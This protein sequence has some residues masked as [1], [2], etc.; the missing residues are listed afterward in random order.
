MK[1]GCYL[2]GITIVSHE[3][4][5]CLLSYQTFSLFNWQ[6]SSENMLGQATYCKSTDYLILILSSLHQYRFTSKLTFMMRLSTNMQQINKEWATAHL[7]WLCVLVHMHMFP[8]PF[9]VQLNPCCESQS[10][11]CI[12]HCHSLSW[13]LPAFAL[14]M[15][16]CAFA[17]VHVFIEKLW[18]CWWGNIPPH[19]S[20]SS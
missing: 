2:Q 20:L 12:S 16:H 14:Q 15:G 7:F 6:C 3:I 5:Y 4:I 10:F 19:A 11:S 17:S 1:W 18:C 13:W 9:H 8:S